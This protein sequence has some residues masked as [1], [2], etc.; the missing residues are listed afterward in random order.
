[1]PGLSK[2]DEGRLGLVVAAAANETA[3]VQ[4][5]G[6]DQQDQA[7]QSMSGVV[8]NRRVTE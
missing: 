6:E 5:R 7:A 8:T 4:H 3:R 1:M 2:G